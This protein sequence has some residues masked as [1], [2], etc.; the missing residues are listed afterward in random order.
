MLSPMLV[1]TLR[2]HAGFRFSYI[3]IFTEPHRGTNHRHSSLS[4]HSLSHP[5]EIGVKHHFSRLYSTI[6]IQL[7]LEKFTKIFFHPFRLIFY[8]S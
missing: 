8:F 7:I 5:N 4:G 2:G 6:N 1:D 3:S